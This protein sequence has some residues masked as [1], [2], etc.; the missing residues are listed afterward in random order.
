M[1]FTIKLIYFYTDFTTKELDILI[2]LQYFYI[3]FFSVIF[4][5]TIKESCIDYVTQYLHIW[6]NSSLKV[7]RERKDIDK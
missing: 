2:E 3:M 4:L 5:K 1:I 7:I 6:E